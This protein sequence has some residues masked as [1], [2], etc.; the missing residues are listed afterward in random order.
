MSGRRMVG[1]TCEMG[2]A[3]GEGMHSGGTA[4]RALLHGVLRIR[5]LAPPPRC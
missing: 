4:G 2:R 5:G 1:L 3:R